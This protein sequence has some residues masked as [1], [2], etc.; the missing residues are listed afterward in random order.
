MKSEEDFDNKLSELVVVEEK[1]E[2][3][4]LEDHLHDLTSQITT[5]EKSLSEQIHIVDRCLKK[6]H[7]HQKTFASYI[8]ESIDLKVPNS[9]ILHEFKDPFEVH[10]SNYRREFVIESIIEVMYDQRTSIPMANI[11][12]KRQRKKNEE[13]EVSSFEIEEAKICSA[14]LPCIDTKFQSYKVEEREKE[15]DSRSGSSFE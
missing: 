15:E 5:N 10:Y 9:L 11:W 14:S 1:K 3:S 13:K 2:Y 7:L 6:I 8:F 12:W 4:M